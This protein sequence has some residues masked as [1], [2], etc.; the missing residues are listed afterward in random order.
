MP[1][2]DYTFGPRHGMMATARGGEARVKD[3]VGLAS[4]VC[5]LNEM[6]RIQRDFTGCPLW[7]AVRMATLTPAEVLGREADVGS[8]SPGRFADI[9]IFDEQV[10]IQAVYVGGAALTAETQRAQR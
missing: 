1:D 3:G 4:S 7:K 10:K 6:V 9:V 8:L 5:P 2:G